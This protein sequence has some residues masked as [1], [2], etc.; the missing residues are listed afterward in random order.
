MGASWYA[1]IAADWQQQWRQHL[2]W[3]GPVIAAVL[4]LAAVVI[5]WVKRWS[6]RPTQVQWSAQDQLS[7]FRT[8]YERGELS[9]EEFDRVRALL[10]ERVKRELVAPAK[11][12]AE[13]RPPEPPPPGN[14]TKPTDA[15]PPP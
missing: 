8:L 14:V 5:A 9:S 6:Q 1:L 7:H 3:A 13:P 11:P 15:E 10:A 2:L 4:L 12:M